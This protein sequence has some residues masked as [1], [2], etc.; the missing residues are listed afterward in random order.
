MKRLMPLIKLLCILVLGLLCSLMFLILSFSAAS[1][2]LGM[3]LSKIN[4]LIIALSNGYESLVK[5]LLVIVISG[6]SAIYIT[7][8]LFPD[9]HES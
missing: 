1:S 3:F 4:D 2:G 9:E 8:K 7:N 5:F 6:S